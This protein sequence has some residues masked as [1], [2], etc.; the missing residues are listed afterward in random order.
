MTHQGPMQGV[1]TGQSSAPVLKGVTLVLGSPFSGS[2]LIGQ[3]LNDIVGIAY[4]GEL[5]RMHRLGFGMH[6]ASR[7]HESRCE[8][9]SSHEG[10]SCPVFGGE[11][12]SVVA[13]GDAVGLDAYLEILSRFRQ[14]YVVD[15]S[16]NVD[17]LWHLQHKG[18]L[19]VLPTNVILTIR[20][21]WA[22][23]IS[24]QRSCGGSLYAAAEGWR[25]IY[26]HALRSIAKLGIPCLTIRHEEF[27]ADVDQWLSRAA[28]FVTGTAHNVHDPKPMH[29]IGGNVSAYAIRGDFDKQGH[30]KSIPEGTQAIA[31]RKFEVFGGEGG[32]RADTL[33]RWAPAISHEDACALLSIPGVMD[34][35]LDL[36]YDPLFMLDEHAAW[37]GRNSDA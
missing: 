8:I 16:K 30:L 12:G 3:S 9:C 21:V 10:V 28:W 19:H 37:R 32:P 34:A 36:G 11:D 23:A 5:D 22:F 29:C 25:N 13:D 31:R 35:M 26:R 17:W 27:V 2:T 24:Q 33:S 7:H 15:G 20:P 4:A 6:V 18:L 14:P 1:G